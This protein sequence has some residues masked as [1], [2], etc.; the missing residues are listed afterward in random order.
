MWPPNKQKKVSKREERESLG[1]KYL[2]P[3]LIKEQKWMK[4]CGRKSFFAGYKYIDVERDNF[5][6]I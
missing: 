5:H 1:A 4:R 6:G 2:R 3:A